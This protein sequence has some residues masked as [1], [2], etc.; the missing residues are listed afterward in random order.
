MFSNPSANDDGDE[1]KLFGFTAADVWQ[2][3]DMIRSIMD[4]DQ[5]LKF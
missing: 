3:E 2:A 4:I 5:D 1:D